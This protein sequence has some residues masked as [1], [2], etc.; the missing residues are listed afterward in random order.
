MQIL[1]GFDQGDCSKIET[2]RQYYTFGQRNRIVQT[3]NTSMDCLAGFTDEKELYPRI[4][5]RKIIFFISKY[6]SVTNTFY[7]FPFCL[8]NYTYFSIILRIC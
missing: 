1:T 8:L 3:L 4:K 6:T 7:L 5:N 2:G